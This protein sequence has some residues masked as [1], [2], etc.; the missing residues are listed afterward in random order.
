MSE[1]CCV[2]LQ[3]EGEAGMTVLPSVRVADRWCWEVRVDKPANISH[4]PAVD[5]E[6]AA[7][8][9]CQ[10]AAVEATEVSPRYLLRYKKSKNCIA[11]CVK[12]KVTSSQLQLCHC[13]S[14]QHA[15][16][17]SGTHLNT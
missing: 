11:V 4:R 14:H 1:V 16:H 8:A 12:Q 17:V 7:V 10:G 13:G 6:A 5:L 2:W 9:V 15:P 3:V